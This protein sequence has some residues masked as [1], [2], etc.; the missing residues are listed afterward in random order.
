[1]EPTEVPRLYDPIYRD[2]AFADI[3]R[4]SLLSEERL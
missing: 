1:M 4:L 2:S 3:D